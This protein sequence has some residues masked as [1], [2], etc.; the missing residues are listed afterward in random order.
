MRLDIFRRPDT[1]GQFSY[2]A[3]PE[4]R[5]IPD[6]ATNVD[7][8]QHARGMDPGEGSDALSQF[9]IDEPLEQITSKGYAISS[10]QH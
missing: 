7:W 5:D 2:L 4:G 1:N 8:E 3:V 9:D 10:V 6:E